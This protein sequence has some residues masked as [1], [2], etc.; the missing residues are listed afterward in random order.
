MGLRQYKVGYSFY[1]FFKRS[2]LKHNLPL[3]RKFGIKKSYFSSISSRDFEGIDE[4]LNWL[5]KEDSAEVLPKDSRF[6]ELDKKTQ[7]SIINWSR[8]GYA[9]LRNHLSDEQVE[10]VNAHVQQLLNEK[11]VSFRYGNKIMFA[12]HVSE[13]LWKIGTS[14]QLMG[15]LELL[16]G[17]E[18]ALFQSINFIEASQQRTHSDSIHMTTFPRGNLVAVWIALE[19]MSE[20]NGA[21]HYYPG[22][23]KLPYLFNKDYDNE[24][25]ALKLGAKSYTDYEDEI[26]TVI[27]QK[28][29]KKEVFTA[30]KG[31]LLIWHAN[32]LHGGEPLK[33]PNRTRKSMALHYYSK[34]VVCYH[35]ITQR[36]ALIT[37]TPKHLKNG[38]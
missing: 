30:K 36:P 18:Q 2:Q 5:D 24:G 27:Q 29:L 22:S 3:Y 31:D 9:I 23:H 6:Q 16:L 11:K 26:E 21:L 14:K 28:N 17:R 20:E 4:E 7:D 25:T 37:P 13:L 15:V 35:E 1:N 12:I 33:D 32:L 34:G 38:Q 19:D 10:E 8:D